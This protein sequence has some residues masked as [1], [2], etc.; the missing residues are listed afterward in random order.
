MASRM[1]VV[2]VRVEYLDHDHGHWCNT[3]ML[4]TGIRFRVAIISPTGM[5][6]QE[7]LWCYEHQGSRGVTVEA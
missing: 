2:S 5:H 1:R 7:R 3:C 4:S 6:L